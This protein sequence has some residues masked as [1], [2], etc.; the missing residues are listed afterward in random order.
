MF[1]TLLVILEAGPALKTKYGPT[2]AVALICIL[3][4]VTYWFALAAHEAGHVLGGAWAG[5]TLVSVHV[6]PI[7]F[8]RLVCRWVVRWDGRRSWL[9]GRVFPALAEGSHVQMAAFVLAGPVASLV[10]G[11]AAAWVAVGELSILLRCWVGLLAIQSLYLG[12]MSLVPLRVAEFDNDGLALCR[13]LRR[14][15]SAGG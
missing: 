6:G 10:L 2:H 4:P 14:D 8:E 13:L 1:G 15:G 12:L 7:T 3:L 5:L 9:N 11:L